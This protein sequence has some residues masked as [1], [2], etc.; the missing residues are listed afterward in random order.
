MIS[1]TNIM[2]MVFTTRTAVATVAIAVSL[3]LMSFSDA[4]YVPSGLGDSTPAQAA[5]DELDALD[6]AAFV[7]AAVRV[8]AR[9]TRAAVNY[10]RITV[11]ATRAYTPEVDRVLLTSSTYT[12]FA[13]LSAYDKKKADEVV[14]KAIK[15]KMKALG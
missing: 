9:A 6:E 10:T 11:E 1:K 2:K 15:T 5:A 7:T 3:S 13:Q 14:S 8:T 12:V 4:T